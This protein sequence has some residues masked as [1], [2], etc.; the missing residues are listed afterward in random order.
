MDS[1]RD[2]MATPATAETLDW[3]DDARERKRYDVV[4]ASDSEM[5]PQVAWLSSAAKHCNHTSMEQV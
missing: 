3:D 1:N 2:A 4:I 5:L